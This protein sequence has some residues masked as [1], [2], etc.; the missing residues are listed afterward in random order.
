MT[1]GHITVCCQ[2]VRDALQGIN[3]KEH[4]EFNQRIADLARRAPPKM[5]CKKEGGWLR[6]S[7][8]H[9]P[10]R[11]LVLQCLGV[12]MVGWGTPIE[13]FHHQSGRRRDSHRGIVN[14]LL[15]VH[16]LAVDG[17]IGVAIWAQS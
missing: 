11:L 12:R 1:L 10:N 3:G 17:L 9:P 4:Q 16:R 14:Q 13:R 15:S 5:P 7:E 2:R 8:G 6:I